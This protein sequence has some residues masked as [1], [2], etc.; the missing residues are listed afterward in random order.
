MSSTELA[1]EALPQRIKR[2]VKN[3]LGPWGVFLE[4]FVRH[5]V[6]VGS[7]VPSSRFVIRK[8][9]AP[10]DWDNCKLFVEYG[11]GVGT[12]CQPVLDRLPRD[13]MLLVIDTN[14]DFIEYL[15]RT[16]TDSRFV[17]VLGSAADVE[18]IVKAH[19]HEKADYVL[20]GLPFSTLPDGVGPAIAAA[21]HRVIR[22]G[23]AFLVYQFTPRARDFMARHFT[24]IDSGLE[25][26]NVPPCC[27]FWGWKDED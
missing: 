12:F 9:L 8:M 4:G 14:P 22:K 7:I 5:P 26:I 20:S 21:T 15:R 16:I 17:A 13:G 19:G 23:G 27:M 10:V 6:M 18:D 2:K 25:V 11:P 1:R 3:A 24:R